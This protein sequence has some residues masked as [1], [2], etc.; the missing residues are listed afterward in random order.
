MT[1]EMANFQKYP[2]IEQA[3]RQK[4]IIQWMRHFP[5]LYGEPVIMQEKLH[6]ANIQFEIHPDGL[7]RTFSRKQYIGKFDLIEGKNSL[8]IGD[9]DYLQ[10]QK[11][12]ILAII[13]LENAYLEVFR[14]LIAHANLHNSIVRIYGEL[15]GPKVQKGV[16]YCDFPKIFFFDVSVNGQF[17]PPIS[18]YGKFHPQYSVLAPSLCILPNVYE[19]VETDIDHI[20]SFYDTPDNFIEGVVIKPYYTT[21]QTDRGI[22][23]LKK[24]NT[25]FE[26]KQKSPKKTKPIDENLKRLNEEFQKYIVPTRIQNVFSKHGPIER[27]EDLGFYIK[28]VMEDAQE[29]FDKD[30]E[31]EL[32]QLNKNELKTVYKIG[33]TVASLLKN[34]LKEG[35]FFTE[36]VK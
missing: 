2:K 18:F 24:K 1:G 14:K 4:T 16:Y 20:K 31:E 23:Y 22:F 28:A 8:D 30:F 27:D 15:C 10:F 17:V 26:E 5:Q 7:V 21:Y 12:D 13:G 11:A 29:D 32:S 9:C 3:Y 19:A 33:G 35:D 6:G 25:K 34:Y 36:T